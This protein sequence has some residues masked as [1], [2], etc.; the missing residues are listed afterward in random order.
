[1]IDPRKLDAAKELVDDYYYDQQERCHHYDAYDAE[2]DEEIPRPADG[3]FAEESVVDAM[4][5][6]ERLLS[7]FGLRLHGYS[8]GVSA[9]DD[10]G[11]TVRFDYQA[12][13]WLERVLVDAVEMREFVQEAHRLLA[14]EGEAERLR[15]VQDAVL[16]AR[17]EATKLSKLR[18]LLA[19]ALQVRGDKKKRDVVQLLRDV[20][21]WHRA[22]GD[23]A[24]CDHEAGALDLL[25]DQLGAMARDAAER[26]DEGNHGEM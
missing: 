11:K 24:V 26:I 13:V 15:I 2:M 21:Q 19:S 1:M 10:C 7:K 22:S 25:A 16:W 4:E 17:E 23:T 9:F 8:P 20:A 12:W 6:V 18:H 5:R 3:H 14:A